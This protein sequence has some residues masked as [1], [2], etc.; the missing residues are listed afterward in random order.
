M[1]QIVKTSRQLTHW[2]DGT[3]STAMSA[4]IRLSVVDRLRLLCG[5]KIYVTYHFL[6]RRD[7]N[8]PDAECGYTLIDVTRATKDSP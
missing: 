2:A 1:G 7:K 5:A 6:D 4:G 8:V 3:R